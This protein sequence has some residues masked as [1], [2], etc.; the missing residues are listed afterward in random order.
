MLGKSLSCPSFRA[1]LV[2]VV[3][4]EDV[5][6]AYGKCAVLWDKIA[7]YRDAVALFGFGKAVGYLGDIAIDVECV[8]DTQGHDA[9]GDGGD[10]ADEHY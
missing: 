7:L 3:N 9:V 4:D 5:V 10:V 2:V 6:D 8:V 1:L